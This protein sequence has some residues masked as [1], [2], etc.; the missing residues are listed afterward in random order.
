MTPVNGIETTPIAPQLGAANAMRLRADDN[1]LTATHAATPYFPVDVTWRAI[2]AADSLYLRFGKRALDVV[3]AFIGLVIA[4]PIIAVAA[5]LIKLDSEGAVFYRQVRLGLKQ[6]PFVFYKLRSMH[7]GAHATRHK[8]L[9]LN[10]VDGPVFKMTNDPRITRVGRFIRKTSI[11]ELPQLINVLRGDMSLVGPRPPLAE[12]VAKYEP[13]QRR[14][15]DVKPGVSCLW[16]ISGR[17][18]LGFDEWM[19]LDME[20]IRR[21]S[22]RLDLHILLRTIPA[23]LSGRGA[24]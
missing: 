11:D 21:M 15:L 13:W 20:Y 9:H 14:R 16:Q 4:A 12:E 22:F 2:H 6:K 1:A 8:I 10:E 18:T 7:D 24:F 3:G 19:R 17:S 23:V 5:I